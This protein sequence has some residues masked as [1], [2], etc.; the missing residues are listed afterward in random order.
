M[1]R[2]AP[3]P[4]R[5]RRDSLVVLGV[6]VEAQGVHAQ[7]QIRALPVLDLEEVD[8]VHLQVLGDLQVLQHRFLSV[9][10]G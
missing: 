2:S 8:A 5:R 7:P 6:D 10:Q 9:G 1:T 4:L 3:S